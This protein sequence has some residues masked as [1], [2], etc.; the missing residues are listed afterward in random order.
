M[1]PTFSDKETNTMTL[2]MNCSHCGNSNFNHAQFCAG[3]GARLNWGQQTQPT[4]QG[5]AILALVLGIIGLFSGGLT[6]VPGAVLS[7]MEMR[8]V[9]AGH[10]PQSNGT[11]AKIAFGVN[12][13]VLALM[14]LSI[15]LTVFFIITLI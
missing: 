2:T 6:A 14:A 1:Q 12:I 11:M 13:A 4:S 8:A 3:C 9:R 10:A 5:R 7:W 15:A